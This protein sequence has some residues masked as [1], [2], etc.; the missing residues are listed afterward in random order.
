MKTRHFAELTYRGYDPAFE[1][2]V[3]FWGDFY[4]LSVEYHIPLFNESTIHIK[5]KGHKG[6]FTRKLNLLEKKLKRFKGKAKDFNVWR[7]K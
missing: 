6:T 1:E 2:L 5:M 3:G 4:K 7:S